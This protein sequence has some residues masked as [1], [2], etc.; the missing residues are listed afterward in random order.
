MKTIRE[1]L[2]TLPEPYRGLALRNL[3]NVPIGTACADAQRDT[4]DEALF[5]AFFWGESPETSDFWYDIHQRAE[6]GE[7]S[8]P[9]ID[10]T[11]PEEP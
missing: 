7:F 4:V 2:K 3:D 6:N 8:K 9:G 5:D 10:C 11:M 1:W